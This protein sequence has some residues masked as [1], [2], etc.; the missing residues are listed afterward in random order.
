MAKFGRR[1]RHRFAAARTADAGRPG[2]LGRFSRVPDTRGEDYAKRLH[3]KET[4]RWKQLLNVQA[5]YRWNL[6]R[7]ELGRTLDVGCGIGRN[8]ETLGEGSLGIDHNPT[9]I[10][11]ARE[12]GLN[13]LTV[14]EWAASALRVA[15]SFDGMLLAHVIE[16][17]PPEMGE[18]VVRDYL[19][20]LRPGGKVLFICPQE[21]GYASDPT[22]VRW[23]T[24][25]DLMD[26]STALGL[27]PAKWRSFPLPR[28]TG[29]A[30]IYNEFN[31]VATK[32]V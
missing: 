4:A 6:R 9:S 16:H 5:P 15:E 25:E 26:L 24:G 14:E 2:G 10:K 17:M 18:Q 27:R 22:H 31:V 21:R 20:Y 11:I 28:F 12:R 1:A 32:P 3:D 29:K 7:H 30:F 23:T 19:P 13:A 8:L